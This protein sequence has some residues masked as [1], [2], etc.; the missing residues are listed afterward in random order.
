MLPGTGPGNV[1]RSRQV[2]GVNGSTGAEI[3]GEK[4]VSAAEG[5]R[6]TKC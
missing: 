6:L 3:V 5:K 1:V 4:N 2:H